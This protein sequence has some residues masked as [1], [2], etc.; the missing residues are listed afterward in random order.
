[1]AVSIRTGGIGFDSVMPV[2]LSGEGGI[3]D[4]RVDFD[5]ALTVFLA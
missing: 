1:L 3:L 2:V 5:T 4:T